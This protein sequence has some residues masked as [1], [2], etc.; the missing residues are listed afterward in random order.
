M[1]Q[2]LMINNDPCRAFLEGFEDLFTF[3][4]PRRQ[5]GLK[6]LS[7]L[8]AG[9]ATGQQL[10]EVQRLRQRAGKNLHVIPRPPTKKV[11]FSGI[12]LKNNE[13]SQKLA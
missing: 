9:K 10:Q 13:T 12:Y 4:H 2:D 7:F 8:F 5:G 1:C 11:F 6:L 3:F